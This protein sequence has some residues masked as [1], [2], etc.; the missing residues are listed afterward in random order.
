MR[1]RTF[2]VL[3]FAAS[4]AIALAVTAARGRSVAVEAA[5]IA[6]AGAV[7]WALAFATRAATG[8]ETL[9]YYH[10]EIAVLAAV[11]AVAAVLGAPVLAHLDAT[12]LGLGAFLSLGRV[13]CLSAGCCHGRPA[14]RGVRYGPAYAGEG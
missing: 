10:H 8:R 2:G 13:G 3:G 11:A 6:T 9:V 5:L 7:F 1:F 14:R 12:A 4:V